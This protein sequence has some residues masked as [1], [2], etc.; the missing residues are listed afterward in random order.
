[1]LT[2][3][4]PLLTHSIPKWKDIFMI[5]GKSHIKLMFPL[6]CLN[7]VANKEFMDVGIKEIELKMI[8][9]T[10]QKLLTMLMIQNQQEDKIQKEVNNHRQELEQKLN[11]L[12]T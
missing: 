12:R 1:M 10:M 5:E 9:V 4:T 8:L 11:T 6:L 7:I 3:L 2:P